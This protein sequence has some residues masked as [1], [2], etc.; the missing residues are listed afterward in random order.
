MIFDQKA[1]PY[2]LCINCEQ[3]YVSKETGIHALLLV[4][5]QKQ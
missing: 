1:H 3:D 4:T 5:F 2:T